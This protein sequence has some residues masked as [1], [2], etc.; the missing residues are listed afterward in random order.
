MAEA[1]GVAAGVISV[2]SLAIQIGD[3][4]RIAIDFWEAVQH[5]PENL[6][7]ICTQLQVLYEYIAEI[8]R[9]HQNGQIHGIQEELFKST[10]V[11]MKRDLDKLTDLVSDLAQ[12]IAPS[13]DSWNRK[14]GRVQM[15]MKEGAIKRAKEYVESA[16]YLLHFLQSWRSQ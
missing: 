6:D 15:A 2:A 14:I 13:Q 7:R 3:S 8:R 10:L 1:F 5:G 12:G 11:M 4:L 9:E 16:T